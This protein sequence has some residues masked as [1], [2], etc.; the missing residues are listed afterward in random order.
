M[1]NN[2]TLEPF[3]ATT[4][5]KNGKM[6][7]TLTSKHTGN[8]PIVIEGAT[9]NILVSHVKGP[10]GNAQFVIQHSRETTTSPP[11]STTPATTEEVEIEAEDIITTTSTTSST[12]TTVVPTTVAGFNTVTSASPSHMAG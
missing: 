3:T 9:G 8:R 6:S 4:Q 12:S 10:D 11:S 2:M 1:P 7:I 5:K